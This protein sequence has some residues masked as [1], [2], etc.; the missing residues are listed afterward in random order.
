MEVDKDKNICGLHGQVESSILRAMSAIERDQDIPDAAKQ[1][2]NRIL[3]EGAEKVRMALVRGQAM[4]R[5]LVEYR[6]AIERCGYRREKD[7]VIQ[8]KQ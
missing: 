7:G 5:K 4:E 8:P 3:K 1:R 6:R 2:V